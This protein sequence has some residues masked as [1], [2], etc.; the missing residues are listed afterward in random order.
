MVR[1]FLYASCCVPA[2][3]AMPELP[4]LACG[5]GLPR[6][7]NDLTSRG[8]HTHKHWLRGRAS[9][10]ADGW[11]NGGKT[12]MLAIFFLCLLT[13]VVIAILIP[14]A[15]WQGRLTRLS[16]IGLAIGFGVPGY[17]LLRVLEHIGASARVSGAVIL[18][19]GLL[20]TAVGLGSLVAF[21]FYRPKPQD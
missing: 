13:G 12:M 18:V 14:R 16:Y 20:L 17:F 2:F 3:T 6:S 21:F 9:L 4:Q 5:Y 8:D 7:G 1:R 11:V 15:A 19:L 10:M